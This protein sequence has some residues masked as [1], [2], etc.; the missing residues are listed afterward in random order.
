[1]QK[2]LDLPKALLVF[3]LLGG[4][5]LGIILFNPPYTVCDSQLELFKKNQTGFIYIAETEKTIKTP[6]IDV[7]SDRCKETNSPGGCYELFMKM[8]GLLS[9]LDRIPSDC[10]SQV[11]SRSEIKN[12]LWNQIKL[13]MNL[14]WGTQPPTNL[15]DK[16]G[17]LDP[18]DIALFCRLKAELDN[19]YGKEAMDSF[20]ETM[21]HD[22]PGA[23][24]ISRTQA[25]EL[26]LLSTDCRA[27]L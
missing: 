12:A 11:T 26:M 19:L 25:W 1:M 13:M 6:M 16:V 8:K 7:L 14:A 24:T 18:A 5:I 10:S 23:S 27:Y 20:R 3:V 15:Y 4:G 17:W 21:F 2:L 9:D 22:L